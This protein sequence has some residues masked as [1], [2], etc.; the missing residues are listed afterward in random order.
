MQHYSPPLS[1]GLRPGSPTSTSIPTS[2]LLYIQRQH[3]KSATKH[4]FATLFSTWILQECCAITSLLA[5]PTRAIIQP[6]RAL[7]RELP[8]NGP[9]KAIDS[10]SAD[11][12]LVEDWRYSSCVLYPRSPA[13]PV[14]IPRFALLLRRQVGNETERGD[15]IIESPVQAIHSTATRVCLYPSYLRDSILDHRYTNSSF[16]GDTSSASFMHP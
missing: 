8:L 11:I 9:S 6:F 5:I 16:S 14:P 2:S 7:E 13:G 15:N 4:P 3:R 12:W 1:I 10:Q